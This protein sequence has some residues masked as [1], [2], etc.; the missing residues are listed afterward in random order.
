MLVTCN[1]G[2]EYVTVDSASLLGMVLRGLASHGWL[3][4]QLLLLDACSRSGRIVARRDVGAVSVK[5]SSVTATNFERELFVAI[6][7]WGEEL[8]TADRLPV[9][10]AVESSV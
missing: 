8:C 7:V 4:S 6:V 9:S 3:S 2:A 1:S 5:L 10:H